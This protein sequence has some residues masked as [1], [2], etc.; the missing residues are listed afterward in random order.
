[1]FSIYCKFTV[2]INSTIGEVCTAETMIFD[3]GGERDRDFWWGRREGA[4]GWC[5]RGMGR[6][7]RAGGWRQRVAGGGKFGGREVGFFC[8]E[9]VDRDGWREIR[10]CVWERKRGSPKRSLIQLMML[11]WH[12]KSKREPVGEPN[13]IVVFFIWW[14]LA[15]HGALCENI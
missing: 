6:R 9:G 3:D 5:R 8:W 7:R 1:M 15:N 2:N 14:Q 11:A 4:L 10:V 13:I 12:A